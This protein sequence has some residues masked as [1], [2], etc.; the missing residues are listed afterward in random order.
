M[1]KYKD[2]ER[3]LNEQR[4]NSTYKR[5]PIRLS[6]DFTTEMLQVKRDWHKIFQVMESNS[7][8]PR[9]FYPARI[10]FKMEGKIKSF[11]NKRR[12]KKVHLHQARTARDAKGTAIRRRR[13]RTRER[14]EYIYGKNGNE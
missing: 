6:A 3:I 9:L 8:H 11:P 14:G 12:L 10:S 5:S 7:L 4:R 13:N 1:A 2:K